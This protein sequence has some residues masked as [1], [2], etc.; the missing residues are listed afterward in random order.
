MAVMEKHWDVCS[1]FESVYIILEQIFCAP[2]DGAPMCNFDASVPVSRD[3]PCYSLYVLS[4]PSTGETNGQTRKRQ[5]EVQIR[6][7][8]G[9]RSLDT[10]KSKKERKKPVGAT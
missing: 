6:V 4:N 2:N 1:G 9:L 7:R 10:R 8:E 3:P 5:R